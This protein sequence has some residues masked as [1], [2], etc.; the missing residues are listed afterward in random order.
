[1][2]LLGESPHEHL[3]RRAIFGELRRHLLAE[4]D[5]RL[6]GDGEAAIER[7][8]IRQCEKIHPPLARLRVERRRIRVAF[9]QPDT[10]EQPLGGLATVFRVKVQVCA[11][12]R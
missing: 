7:V 6:S 3:H 5:T 11:H 4:K 1:M 2:L 8:A 9:R 10:A 12:C